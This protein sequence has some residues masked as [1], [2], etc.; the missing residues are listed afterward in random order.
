MHTGTYRSVAYARKKPPVTTDT[1]LGMIG[2]VMIILKRSRG[3]I[4]S[5]GSSV[6]S[7]AAASFDSFSSSLTT[8]YWFFLSM[9]SCLMFCTELM[10]TPSATNAMPVRAHARNVRSLAKWSRAV[11]PELGTIS[12]A[13]LIAA[14][15]A[16][17]VAAFVAAFVATF[18]TAAVVSA[19]ACASLAASASTDPDPASVAALSPAPRV[20]AFE[21]PLLDEL[22]LRLE[23]MRQRRAL[24]VAGMIGERH[25]A[26]SCL[27][28]SPQRL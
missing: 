27:V 7:S 4:Y 5:S 6:P 11:L 22:W 18:V 28:C 8:V 12:A 13:T 25:I 17:L 24:R 2:S 14:F 9:L 3:V 1:M 23:G 10:P 19:I 15:V 16:A 21:L 26:D 20:D